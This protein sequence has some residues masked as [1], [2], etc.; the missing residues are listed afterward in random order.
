MLTVEFS[1]SEPFKKHLTSGDSKRRF[2]PGFAPPEHIQVRLTVSPTEKRK[3]LRCFLA[4]IPQDVVC[5]RDQRQ[6]WRDLL[7]SKEERPFDGKLVTN[8]RYLYRDSKL[9]AFIFRTSKYVQAIWVAPSGADYEYGLSIGLCTNTASNKPYIHDLF[10]F[11]SGN[12]VKGLGSYILSNDSWT[13]EEHFC[14]KHGRPHYAHSIYTK[15]VTKDFIAEVIKSLNDAEALQ[16]PGMHI[17]DHQTPWTIREVWV[18][19]TYSYVDHRVKHGWGHNKLALI[20]MQLKVLEPV[21]NKYFLYPD[22]KTTRVDFGNENPYTPTKNLTALAYKHLGQFRRVKKI[23]FPFNIVPDKVVP[24]LGQ[25]LTNYCTLLHSELNYHKPNAYYSTEKLSNVTTIREIVELLRSNSPTQTYAQRQCVRDG[26]IGVRGALVEW[27]LIQREQN[28]LLAYITAICI[29]NKNLDVT[30]NTIVRSYDELLESPYIQT[31]IIKEYCNLYDTYK[32]DLLLGKRSIEN[33]MKPLYNLNKICIS[34]FII[35]NTWLDAAN[36]IP[37]LIELIEGTIFSIYEKD[38]DLPMYIS[39]LDLIIMFGT[40]ENFIKSFDELPLI[41]KDG[42]VYKNGALLSKCKLEILSARYHLERVAKELDFEQIPASVVKKLLDGLHE[43]SLV[44]K[45]RTLKVRSLR[46]I[47][48]PESL[49]V[50][51][52]TIKIL[53]KPVVIKLGG[54]TWKVSQITK[55]SSFIRGLIQGMMVWS[56]QSKELEERIK[57]FLTPNMITLKIETQGVEI[58]VAGFILEGNTLVKKYGAVNSFCEHCASTRYYN[59]Y[60]AHEVIEPALQQMQN[61][62]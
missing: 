39:D 18:G 30:T 5:K 2:S 33:L 51:A 32:V 22:L 38:T 4:I 27:R 48:L 34:L 49:S 45:I 57:N 11:Y 20:K 28:H 36:D 31:L 62:L 29:K 12:T 56:L 55:T 42:R 24:K 15:L 6:A 35:V 60:V 10:D 9:V 53:N 61:E 17:L 19:L 8:C 7:D 21:I 47:C 41:E 37:R 59:E 23:V 54:C 13:K 14:T 50:N 46:E 58:A 1:V 43:M 44:K 16:N 52:P 25:V 40:Y 3:D 26:L